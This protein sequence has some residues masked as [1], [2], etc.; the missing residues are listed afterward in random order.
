MYGWVCVCARP[1]NRHC[2][3]LAAGIQNKKERQI[4]TCFFLSFL[5]SVNVVS[6][7]GQ[8]SLRDH[9]SVLCSSDSL[10]AAQHTPVSIL[11]CVIAEDVGGCLKCVGEPSP[12]RWNRCPLSN[13]TTHCCDDGMFLPNIFSGPV[14]GTDVYTIQQDGI[15]ENINVHKINSAWNTFHLFDELCITN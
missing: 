2:F 7:L 15:I 5:A 9:V 13:N 4:V 3:R 1:I 14:A 12:C 10:D 6:A 8:S 11:W